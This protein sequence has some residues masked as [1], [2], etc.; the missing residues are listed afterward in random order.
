M[1]EK[2]FDIA[3]VQA[4]VDTN[5]SKNTTNPREEIR[6]PY[7]YIHDTY[8]YISNMTYFIYIY[9]YLYICIY[10]CIHIYVYIYVYII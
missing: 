9:I 5:V 6:I 3:R 8:I 4:L 10:I 2:F 7:T 1:E